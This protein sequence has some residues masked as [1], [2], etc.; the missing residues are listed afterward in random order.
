[1]VR[2]SQRSLQYV[3]DMHRNKDIW[4]Q[5]ANRN[6]KLKIKSD[7]KVQNEFPSRESFIENS[8]FSRN[9]VNEYITIGK[10]YP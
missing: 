8:S 3:I 10:G 5:D 1:M 4:E 6:W 2:V 9:N 7:V